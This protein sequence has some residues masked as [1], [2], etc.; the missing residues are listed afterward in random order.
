MSKRKKATDL[1]QGQDPSSNDNSMPL[2]RAVKHLAWFNGDSSYRWHEDP[3]LVVWKYCFRL[4][5]ALR[6]GRFKPYGLS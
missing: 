4:R 1:S 3:G 6:A 5:R 2:S